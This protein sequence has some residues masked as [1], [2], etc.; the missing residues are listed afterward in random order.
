MDICLHFHLTAIGEDSSDGLPH[1]P[2]VQAIVRERTGEGGTGTAASGRSF[3]SWERGGAEQQG[4]RWVG[5]AL[6]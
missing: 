2:H 6:R 3:R 5:V 1:P 4:R